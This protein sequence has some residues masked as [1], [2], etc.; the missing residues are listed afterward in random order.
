M[1]TKKSSAIELLENITGGLLTLGDLLA[2]IRLGEGLTQAKFASQLEISKSHL[3]DIEKG[4]KTVSL[5]RATRFARILGYS[6]VQFMRLALQGMVEEAGLG[7]TVQ[8]A[9]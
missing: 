8:V 4:R 6:E 7:F 2:S 9:A 3:C 5:K 1:T